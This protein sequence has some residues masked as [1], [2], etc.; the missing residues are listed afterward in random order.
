[1][2]AQLCSPA[3]INSKMKGLKIASKTIRVLKVTENKIGLGMNARSV[4]KSPQCPGSRPLQEVKNQR[5]PSTGDGWHGCTGPL[6][7]TL[8]AGASPS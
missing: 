8:L 6:S 2:S 7:G 5:I 4:V 3:G 1:M